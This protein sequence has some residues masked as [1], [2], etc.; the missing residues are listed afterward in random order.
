MSITTEISRLKEAKSDIKTAI[1]SKGVS[2]GN[3]SIDTYASY[4]NQIDNVPAI[5]VAYGTAAATVNKV[6]SDFNSG[7]VKTIFI[8]KADGTYVPATVSGTSIYGIYTASGKAKKVMYNGSAWSDTDVQSDIIGA[9]PK[10]Y[11]TP[12][13]IECDL[14]SEPTLTSAQK[15]AFEDPMQ[16]VRLKIAETAYYIEMMPY[17]IDG[18]VVTYRMAHILSGG[19]TYLQFRVESNV[20]KYDVATFVEQIPVATLSTSGLVRVELKDANSDYG[21]LQSSIS[22]KLKVARDKNGVLAVGTATSQYYGAVKIGTGLTASDGVVSLDTTKVASSTVNGFMSST[23]KTRLDSLKNYTLP[24]ATS[25]T[26][27]GVKIGSNITVSSGTISLTAVNISGALGYTPLSSFTVADSS[28]T[29]ATLANGA[30]TTV[31][32]ADSAIIGTKISAKTI[33]SDKFAA[34]VKTNNEFKLNT[35]GDNRNVATKPSDYSANLIFKG[36]KNVGIIG[37]PSTAGT[38]AA[39]LGLRSWTDYS[40]GASHELAFTNTD[41]YY[42]KSDAKSSGESWNEWTTIMTADEAMTEADIDEA[43]K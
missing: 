12:V 8:S 7:T 42:R 13:D 5:V 31:K 28:I 41:I 35:E 32:V 34:G 15:N 2:V 38:Y 30:V 25:S 14:T 16:F 19:I 43:I 37:I 36:L 21:S 4:I 18:G 39:L 40:G 1:Q 23:D 6:V 24:S 22:P 20:L 27:G 33:T 29:T 26:L 9:F 11:L 10:T 17:G 3:G